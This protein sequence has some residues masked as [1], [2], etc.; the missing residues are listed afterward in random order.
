MFP[1]SLPLP[2]NTWFISKRR[3]KS[4]NKNV[5]T[6]LNDSTSFSMSLS[7]RILNVM[8]QLKAKTNSFDE[9]WIGFCRPKRELCDY[10]S[11]WVADGDEFPVNDEFR[12]DHRRQIRRHFVVRKW[13]SNLFCVSFIVWLRIACL[14]SAGGGLQWMG[15]LLKWKT[16]N[17]LITADQI[18]TPFGKNSIQ[19][20]ICV[21][22]CVR[23]CVRKHP[24]DH[25]HALKM[26]RIPFVVR[27]A[28]G[29]FG[30]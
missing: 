28:N 30:V 18:F 20:G 5:L 3:T 15:H 25:R 14:V 22:Y 19:T 26:D 23:D 4:R 2:I 11:M 9:I 16:C 29:E 7:F 8:G 21:I 27:F 6:L 17:R 12:P 10:I 1:V 13:F 24:P